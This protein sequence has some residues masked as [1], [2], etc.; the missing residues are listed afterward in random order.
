M[1][2]IDLS[3]SK[4]G[5]T[6]L[7]KAGYQFIHELFPATVNLLQ[8]LQLL[9]CIGAIYNCDRIINGSHCSFAFAE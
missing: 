5:L 7:N 4:V 8:S 2:F 1:Q 3:F 6:K 9:K